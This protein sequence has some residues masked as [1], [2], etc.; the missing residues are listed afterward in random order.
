MH[1][2]Q[3]KQKKLKKKSTSL[4]KIFPYY[5]YYPCFVMPSLNPG[6]SCS[7]YAFFK[8]ISS[9]TVLKILYLKKFLFLIY[10]WSLLRGGKRGNGRGGREEGRGGED[11]VKLLLS[12]PHTKVVST[13]V[14]SMVNI[15]ISEAVSSMGF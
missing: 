7:Q 14:L 13:A 4:T 9:I 11:K 15:H 5:K 2:V 3:R 10:V 6:S 1:I 12:V 8:Y